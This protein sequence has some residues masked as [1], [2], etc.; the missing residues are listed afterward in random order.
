MGGWKEKGMQEGQ[1]R[2]MAI[3]EYF[4]SNILKRKQELFLAPVLNKG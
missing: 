4:K 1:K 3:K 2:K